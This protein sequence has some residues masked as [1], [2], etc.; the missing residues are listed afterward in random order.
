MAKYLP[1]GTTFSFGGV[2]V[3]GLISIG[4]PDRTRGAAEITDS[5]SGFNRDY[6]PGLRDTGSVEL[7]FRHDPA[8]PGQ[9]A[10]VTNFNNDTSGNVVTCILTLPA[11]AGGSNKIYTFDAFVIK[12]PSG[13]LGLTDDTVAELS[14]T[15]Q[16]ASPVVIS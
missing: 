11:I 10:L 7:Q 16:V 8:D 12:A 1:H 13:A 14:C 3:A 9:I 6:I 5:G 4:I 15:L 2:A